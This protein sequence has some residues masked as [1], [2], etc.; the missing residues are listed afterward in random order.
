MPVYWE[1]NHQMGEE[2]P[3]IH[4]KSCFWCY[5]GKNGKNTISSLVYQGRHILTCMDSM[6]QYF[7]PWKQG[8]NT[9]EVDNLNLTEPVWFTSASEKERIH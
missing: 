4:G 1:I 3:Y 7:L 8:Q 6:F 2:I 5:T 9:T